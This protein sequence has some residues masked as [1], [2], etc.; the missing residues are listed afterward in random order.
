[1]PNP[2]VGPFRKL[3]IGLVVVSYA[4]LA[5]CSKPAETD[6]SKLA[7]GP[8][9][10]LEVLPKPPAQPAGEFMD[11]AGAKHTLA[12]FKG[13]VAV[14][15]FW[16]TWCAPCV[17][18]MPGL[19]SLAGSMKGKPVVFVPISVDKVEDKQFAI[20]RLGQLSSKAFDFYSDPSYA[21]VY[22]A[23]A[24]GL[25]T[26]VIYGKDGVELARL[27]GGDVDWASPEAKLMLEAALAK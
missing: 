2:N 9:A 17:K 5:G 19:A 14:V 26:T 18:E 7:V 3:L 23:S 12:E 15:N 20:D 16:A 10:K 1:M 4:V 22:D 6:L 27:S 11:A 13:K 8:L 21:M 25:P 24:A